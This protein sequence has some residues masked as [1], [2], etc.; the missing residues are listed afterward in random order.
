MFL[1][2][3]F[4]GKWGIDKVWFESIECKYICEEKAK[5]R[6]PNRGKREWTY[7]KWAL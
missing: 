6:K 1:G 4:G 7:L 5:A 3:H 2:V